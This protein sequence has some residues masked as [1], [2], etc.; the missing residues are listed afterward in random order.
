MGTLEEGFYV[1]LSYWDRTF[2]FFFFNVFLISR[3]SLK[4]FSSPAVLDK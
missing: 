2:F 3:L 1:M 4:Y